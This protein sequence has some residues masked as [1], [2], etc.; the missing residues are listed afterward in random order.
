MFTLY[1]IAFL[2]DTLWHK[3][4]THMEYRTGP[5]ERGCS[6]FQSSLLN[7]FFRLRELLPSLLVIREL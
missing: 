1:W 2:A 5:D 3:P 6:K 4:F 7:I